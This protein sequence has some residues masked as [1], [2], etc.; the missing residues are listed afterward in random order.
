MSYDLLS[1]STRCGHLLLSSQGNPLLEEEEEGVLSF[2]CLMR[3]LLACDCDV[4]FLCVVL[5]RESREVCYE[6]Q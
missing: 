1:P 2:L 5:L 6:G 4:L 3:I